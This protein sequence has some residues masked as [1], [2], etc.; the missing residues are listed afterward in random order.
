[1][2]SQTNPF[3]HF[4]IIKDYRQSAKVNHKL[5]DIILLTVC[6]VLSGFDTWEGIRDFGS[7]RIDFLRKLGHFENGIPSADTV[8]RVMGMISPKAM[9]ESFIN[10]MQDCHEMTNGDVIAI[11]GKTV[12]GSYNKSEDR[13]AIHM[14][15]AFATKQGLCLAQSKVDAKTNEITEI[16]KLLELLN[17]SGCLITIDAMGCQKKIAQKIVDK[18]ADYL[19]AVKGNQGSLEQAISDFYKPSMLQKFDDGDSYSTQEKSHGRVETR[20]ALSATNLSFLGDLEYEWPGIKSVGIMVNIR[21]EKEQA[22]ESE[23]SVRFLY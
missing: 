18:N 6:G 1:M 10:W 12:R 5:S 14:V 2:T 11:D 13:A 19:L 21:Q 23:L 17:I 20:C 3:M 8:A 16:P 4:E 22:D 15:N 7:A 9:Q